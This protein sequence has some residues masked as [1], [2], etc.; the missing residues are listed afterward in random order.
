MRK[1]FMERWKNSIDV[2]LPSGLFTLVQALFFAYS[3]GLV[4]DVARVAE[5]TPVKLFPK[6]LA[7]AMTIAAISFTVIDILIHRILVENSDSAITRVA[8]NLFAWGLATAVLVLPSGFSS[9]VPF[10]PLLFVLA[11]IAGAIVLDLGLSLGLW[12]IIFA[13]IVPKFDELGTIGP[14]GLLGTLPLLILILYIRATMKKATALG[15]QKHVVRLLRTRVL[16]AGLVLGGA[17][18]VSYVSTREVVRTSP[19][20]V[21]WAIHISNFVPGRS[22]PLEIER[23]FAP[24]EIRSDNKELATFLVKKAAVSGKDLHLFRAR[25][26][27]AKTSNESYRLIMAAKYTSDDDGQKVRIIDDS[28]EIEREEK[29]ALLNHIEFNRHGIPG[30]DIKEFERLMR[31]N[32][33]MDVSWLFGA[34]PSDSSGAS[35]LKSNARTSTSWTRPVSPLSEDSS[36]VNYQLVND[37]GDRRVDNSSLLLVITQHSL[38]WWVSDDFPILLYTTATFTPIFYGLIFLISFVLIILIK[39]DRVSQPTA[40]TD[41][42]TKESPEEGP[43]S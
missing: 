7:I 21:A 23:N 19:D 14:F 34:K 20:A 35:A 9:T 11:L 32:Q 22:I 8:G 36:G 30:E 17:F 33:K 13:Q 16:L 38:R 29:R 24:E 12:L 3:F 42:S 10:P 37:A 15:N 6:D 26:S 25:E 28:N 39:R 18:V 1:A 40:L 2:H 41:E 31:V 5:F 4:L 27:Q 43:E